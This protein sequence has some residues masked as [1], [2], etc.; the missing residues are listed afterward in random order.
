MCLVSCLCLF[1]TVVSLIRNYDCNRHCNLRV[2]VVWV[3]ALSRHFVRSVLFASEPVSFLTGPYIHFCPRPC[4]STCRWARLATHRH[5]RLL[6]P[7]LAASPP[8][9]SPPRDWAVSSGS[10]MQ[11]DMGFCQAPPHLG[12]PFPLFD[13]VHVRRA[14]SKAKRHLHGTV[15]GCVL[16]SKQTVMQ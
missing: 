11:Q 6:V 14:G 1:C 5:W 10:H 2:H 12:A 9:V 7:T 3:V 13:T 4:S 8:H 15:N 16:M